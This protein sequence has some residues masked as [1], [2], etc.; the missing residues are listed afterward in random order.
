MTDP[1]GDP[2]STAG[3]ATGHGGV[4][5]KSRNTGGKLVTLL[6]RNEEKRRQEYKREDSTS[7]TRST[8]RKFR[9][10]SNSKL[11]FF[12]F[13]CNV[14]KHLLLKNL[15]KSKK[16]GKEID[17]TAPCSGIIQNNVIPVIK[18][19]NSC[20][21]QE[22]SN[23]EQTSS[24]IQL[25]HDIRL[26]NVL[27]NLCHGIEENVDNTQCIVTDINLHIVPRRQQ[28]KSINDI[29]TISAD[30]AENQPIYS[31]ATVA[32]SSA[33]A[34]LPGNMNETLNEHKVK[35]SLAKELLNLSKYGW[36]WGPISGDE[37]DAKLISE[38][39][40]AFLVRDSSDD[41]YVLTLSFK[42]SGKMLHARMEHSG[43]LFSL[44]NQCTENEGFT[45]VAALINHAMNFSQSSVICYSRP[46]YPGYPSFPVRL[47]KP[48]SRFTQVRSLQYLCRF[49]IRQYTRLDNIHKLP[50]PKTIKGYIQEAHY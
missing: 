39:D 33:M 30:S 14:K 48:V 29:A 41:R 11:S 24:D 35:A 50:L 5:W 31:D 3:T 27:E 17:I 9:G 1:S 44:C 25:L 49:V 8:E 10:S 2:E 15:C 37:A 32:V 42:S 16:K 26:G 4:R 43:G 40:G 21:K 36:Y 28:N 38:P 6:R 7:D 45:S 20:Q 18:S 34:E 19:C 13:V 47:T 46:K 12:N 23:N 22:L